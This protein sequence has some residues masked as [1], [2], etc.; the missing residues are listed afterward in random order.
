MT[1]PSVKENAV[2]TEGKS[3]LLVLAAS[4]TP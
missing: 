3:R 4:G 1:T 2:N